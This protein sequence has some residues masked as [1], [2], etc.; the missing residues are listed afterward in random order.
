MSRSYKL[1]SLLNLSRNG[2]SGFAMEYFSKHYYNTFIG[3][4]NYKNSGRLGIHC[5][6]NKNRVRFP[7]A[8]IEWINRSWI[9][10]IFCAVHSGCD[11][12]EIRQFERCKFSNKIFE[13]WVGIFHSH[14]LEVAVRTDLV[15][16]LFHANSFYHSF[17]NFYAEARPILNIAAPSVTSTIRYPLAPWISTESK[18]AS[19]ALCA[20]QPQTSRQPLVYLSQT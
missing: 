7:H 8:L 16:D 6:G 14:A 15:A 2:R 5:T 19:N 9:V 17:S 10:R 1:S 3:L 13:S 20:A 11:N 12:M 4:L 18:P